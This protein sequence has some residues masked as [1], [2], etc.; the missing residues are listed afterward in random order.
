MPRPGS[1][2]SITPLTVSTIVADPPAAIVAVS[3]AAPVAPIV[4]AVWV[5]ANAV[6]TAGVPP[7]PLSVGPP[8]RASC[9][10]PAA[11]VGGVEP[12][13]AAAGAPTV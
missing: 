11:V 2:T 5:T 13:D 7:E 1:F 3:A 4:I 10:P 12:S 6:P 8:G 9:S